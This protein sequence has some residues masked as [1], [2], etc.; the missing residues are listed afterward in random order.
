[1]KLL[2][3]VGLSA[4]SLATVFSTVVSVKTGPV[5]AAEEFRGQ[6]ETVDSVNVDGNVV[7]ISYNNGAIAGKI[8]FL[9]NGIFRYNVDPSGEFGEYAEVRK[10]IPGYNTHTAKIQAQSDSSDKYSHPDA[11]V[12]DKGTVWEISTDEATIV[13]DK[14]TAK[15]SIKNKSGETIMS[16]AEPLVI[17]NKTVQSLDTKADEY[18]FGGGTQNGRFTHKGKSIN[19][20]N[21]SSWTDG[22]VSSPN[23]FYWSTEGY[24]VLRNTFKDG[25]YDFGETSAEVVATTHNESE[26]DAYYF[27]SNDEDVNGK[28]ETLL[29]EYY[30][31]TGNPMLLP[32]YAFYLA[33]LNCY[34]RDGWEESTSGNWVLEDGKTYRELGQASGYVIP[35][36]TYAETLNNE[37]PSVDADNFKG[38]VN[39]DTYK[40]SAR[41]VIDGHVDND[42]PLGWFLPNDGYGCGYGQNGYYQTRTSGEDTTRR[43]SVVDANVANLAS[44]TEYA[45]ANGV[46]SGLW[47][48]AALTPDASEQDSR[49]NGFQNLRD[50]NKEVNVAGVS[51]LKTDVA[52][53]G[54]GYSMALNSVKDGYNILASSGK[55]PTVVSLDGWAG[56]Q[57]YASVWTGDQTGGNWEYIRF[58]IPTYIG[59]SLSGNPNVGSDVDGIFGGSDLITTRDLQFKTFT[60]TMLDMDGWGSKAKKP[61]ITTDPYISINRMYLKLKA[62]LMPYI[63]TAAHEAVDGL[64]MIRAMFLEEA[65][66]YTYSTATQYQYMFGDN[67]LVAP[68]YQDTNADEVGNDVRNNIY[69]PGTSDTWI[70]YFTGEQYRGG[71][72]INNFDAPIW[73]LP[74]FVKNGSII[75]MYEENNNPMAITETNEKGLDKTR[76]I[77]EFYPYGETS[78]DLVEDD[79]IT[80]NYD[81]ATNERDYG[82]EVTTH[83]TSKVEGDT[84]TL[85]IGA[86]KGTYEGYDANRHTTFVVNVSKE[87]TGLIAKNGNTNVELTKVGSYEEFEAAAANNEAV[88]FYDEAPNLNKYSMDGEAFKDTEITTTPKLYVSFPKT[89]VDDNAQTLVVNGFAN[90]GNIAADKLNENLATPANLAAPEEEITPTSIN[91][92]WDAVEDATGY[93]LLI[94]GNLNSVGKINSFKHTE[95]TY[96]SEHTYKVRA[97]NAEGYS[98]WS[99]ELK[100]KTLLDPWRN[101]LDATNI[102]WPNSVSYGSMS[103]AFD[104]DDETTG[105]QSPMTNGNNS[106]VFD[107]GNAYALDKF[108]F[109]PFFI[110]DTIYAG[111]VTKMDISVSL[112]GV[113]WQ[114]VFDGNENPWAYDK[115]TKVVNFDDNV[116]GRYVKLT[117]VETTRDYFSANGL[118]LYKKDGTSPFAVGSISIQGR[119]DVTDSDYTNLNNYKGLSIKDDP[120]F[121]NQVKNYGMDI[122]MNDIYDVYDYAFT[123]FKLDG[124][125]TKKGSVSGN[126]LLLPSVETV[127][128][129]ETFTIDVYADNVKNLNAIGQ[130]VNYDPSKVEYV[131]IKQDASICTM[132]DLTVNK[133]YDDGTAYVNMAF[134]N[135]GDKDVY[136]GSGIVATITMT[137]KEDI[138][139][140]NAVDLSKVTLIGP[141]YSYVESDVSNAPE[142]PEIP[143]ITKIYYGFNDFDITMTNNYYPE[144][145]GTNVKKFIQSGSYDSY[146]TLF[147]GSYGREF[148]LLWD[149]ESNYVDGKFPEHVK[150]PMTLHFDLKTPSKLNEVSVFNS[151]TQGNGYLTSAKAQLIFEDGTK[152][153]E[154]TLE[155]KG[156]EFVFAW[157]T[158]KTVTGVDVTAL[159]ATGSEDNHMLTLSEVQLKYVE[160]VNVEG[161]ASADTNVTELKVGEL[162]DINA[163][164]TPNNA[165]NKF[166]KVTSS[167][168]DVV[169]IVTLADEN[170]YPVYKAY[171]VK[172]GKA[173]ITLIS[174]ADENITATYEITVT[175]DGEPIITPDKTLL[176]IAVDV[177]SQITEE[178]LADVVPAVVNEF[179]AALT[180]A[181]NILA[182]A[183]ATEAQ[184]NAS[185]DRLANAMHMLSFIKGDKALLEAFVTKVDNLTSEAYIASTWESFATA[186]QTSKDVLANENAMQDEINET[187]DALVRAFLELRLK[188]NKDLLTDLIKKVEGL[189][190]AKYTADTFA[191]LDSKLAEARAVLDNEDADQKA[192]NAAYAALNSAFE[193]LT[194]IDSENSTVPELPTNPALPSDS[195]TTVKTGDTSAKESAI[196]TGDTTSFA[197]VT[198]L[199]ASI[200]VLAYLALSRKKEEN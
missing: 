92:T 7:N 200:A 44:F 110:G 69:L 68:V 142:I 81:E 72:I 50:F 126:A 73:K 32:E 88:Y 37:G 58:H 47:T 83:I 2:K 8:T 59:Q 66:D 33:H 27:V 154:I 85:T 102:Q 67:F 105:F 165:P 160:E 120:T 189:N 124:G 181:Q 173:T 104:H 130:V 24:G 41:A 128:A 193:G 17:S 55:R 159:T 198:T 158:D 183:Y 16:E 178:D 172:A 143:A 64:P 149:I 137:A 164:V 74:L 188:P 156:F 71:Q 98:A 26:F 187:Y 141:N 106:I 170:G 93:E 113:H 190:A 184:I 78:Y 175:K 140:A 96:D 136:N 40:F 139:V 3:K 109:V 34:N 134:A 117:I 147:N 95:L 148:E 153:E 171:G 42:M 127:K 195:G 152:S 52:W 186:L 22:G 14:A 138:V 70:D 12:S 15:M 94:D 118:H 53:V 28:A 123:M 194:V 1:M 168:T 169:K 146:A 45:E 129:G 114:K 167:D 76:R 87:P 61:Y 35:E 31:V 166:F 108:E 191:V 89:N 176:A 182:D 38:T 20:A 145:D 10:D 25:K 107:Y 135:R 99:D 30:T 80:L 174:A 54:Y 196:K 125:T 75:P 18:F 9:E 97:V 46:R 161:I 51:A 112:D 19:I 199:G 157:D 13:L 11:N 185:F 60:Q 155:N 179:N 29:N 121:T 48:Q 133:V 180:E 77:V 49:Y 197:G 122:N 82:G 100:V 131:S 36:N 101:T 144:D 84:A 65:N 6:L 119:T 62:Q 5:R 162:S 79:G 132:E 21:E 4:L 43:D 163:V 115:T 39:E 103:N 192:V 86:S 90:E 150:L 57:R 111:L 151:Q 56:F 116:V 177:A 23:P 63:Y 91:V